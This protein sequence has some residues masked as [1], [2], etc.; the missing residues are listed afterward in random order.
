VTLYDLMTLYDLN[1]VVLTS[2]RVDNNFFS[3]NYEFMTNVCR[4]IVV[5]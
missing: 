1:K 3:M 2:N 4:W 5:E